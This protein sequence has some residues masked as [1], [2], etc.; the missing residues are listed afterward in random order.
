MVI[1]YADI[2][3]V[4]TMRLN[5]AKSLSESV[6]LINK[7]VKE[8]NPNFPVEIK[9]IDSLNEIKLNNEKILG[10]L[11]NLFGCLAIFV[12]CLGLFGLSSFSTSQRIK[13]VSIRK[14]LGASITEL[15]TLL[16]L[17]FIKL[18]FIAIVISLPIAYYIMHDWLQHFELRTSLSL[19]MFVLTATLTLLISILTITWQTYHAAKI[20]AV[21]WWLPASRGRASR[22]PSPSR[23]RCTARAP[24][25]V[26]ARSASAGGWTGR[27]GT[28]RPAHPRVRRVRAAGRAARDRAGRRGRRSAC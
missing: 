26:R 12:S 23:A 28:R 13:E 19:W 25:A 8:I 27:R 17:N 24:S 2:S 16:S 4:I 9:F 11:A 22:S 6:D 10:T 14:I 18:I 20:N 21:E 3:D 7:L 1:A 5:P 15:M